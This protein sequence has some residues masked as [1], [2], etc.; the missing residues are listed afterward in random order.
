MRGRRGVHGSVRIV[1]AGRPRRAHE[2][3]RWQLPTQWPLACK[4]LVQKLLQH[5]PSVSAVD[6]AD[7]EAGP[8]IIMES[9][10]ESLRENVRE[11]LVTRNV[12]HPE[13]ADGHF[14]P[15]EVDIELDMLGA[16]VMYW[17]L[18]HVD[19]GDIQW[20]LASRHDAWCPGILPSRRRCRRSVSARWRR[21]DGG[22]TRR[23]P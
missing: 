4:P 20:W 8:E 16:P 15:D 12:K 11:L 18:G 21:A 7:A 10:R 2:G 19:R 22:R 6:M 17:I 5:P 1:G 9:R 13:L 23:C 14:F 3:A